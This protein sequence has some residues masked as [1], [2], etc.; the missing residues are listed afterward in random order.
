M[1]NID[2]NRIPKHIAM[3]LDGNGRWAKKRMLPRNFGHRNG[4]FNINKVAG[5]CDELGVKYLTMYCFSTEN[6]NRPEKE[7]DYLMKAPIRMF[8]RLKPQILKSNIRWKFIGRRDRFP[9]EVFDL[10]NELEDLTKDKTGLTLT[11]CFDY[12][13]YEELTTAVKKIAQDCVDGKLNPKDITPEVIENNLYTAGYPKLDLLIR[14]S[15]EQRIS[16]FLLWQ[17]AYA[18]FYFTDVLWPDF[19]KEEL[20]KAIASYQKRDRRFGGLNDNKKN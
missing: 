11:I 15:G 18:E 7:V 19:D 4:A 12:G 9:K 13:S 17:I 5:Y 6:W 2:M 3:I 20:Y 1:E 14:T 10:I 16:N 8:N